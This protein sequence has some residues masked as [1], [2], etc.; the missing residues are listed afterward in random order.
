[1]PQGRR[2][3]AN[4]GKHKK[5]FLKG[6]R[7][8][9]RA[10]SSSIANSDNESV[11]RI[12]SDSMARNSE[13][14]GDEGI[15]IA[16]GGLTS[17]AIAKINAQPDSNAKRDANRYALH[18][19]RD[20]DK[21]VAGRQVI[22]WE[23]Y[24]LLPPE[25]LQ[26]K[27][28]DWWPSYDLAFPRRP[29]W[30][31][32]MTTEQVD[33]H[34]QES[35]KQFLES[36]ESEYGSL[37]NLSHFELNLE[38][39]RQLWRV[40]EMADIVLLVADIRYPVFHFP[41]AL[42][43]YTKDELKKS[44]ILVLNKCDLVDASVVLA[45]IDYFNKE[46]PDIHVVPFAS[47][48][49]MRIGNAKG[50]RIGRLAMA[51]ESC[52]RLSQ[53]C[54]KIV[55]DKVNLTEWK[56]KIERELKEEESSDAD[57]EIKPLAQVEHQIVKKDLSRYQ[58]EKYK[59][60]ILTI[61]CIGHPN[62]GK[63]SVLNA[64]MGKKVVSVSRTP[65][66]TKYFQ[67]IFITSNVKLVDCPGLVFPSKIPKSL[68]V[69]MGC[70]PIAQLREPY[71]CIRFIAERVDLPKLLSLQHPDPDEKGK[72]DQEWSAHEVCEAWA[73]K[74]GF[75]TAKAARPDVYRAANH[76][77]RMALDGR[78][79]CLAFYPPQFI[80]MRDEWLKHKDIDEIKRLQCQ[81][82]TSDSMTD[83]YL[84]QFDSDDDDHVTGA[85]SRRGRSRTRRDQVLKTEMLKMTSDDE[86][87]SSPSSRGQSTNKFA[88]LGDE[89]F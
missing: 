68:Q 64:I 57:E 15:S 7:E 48:A 26:V 66:H 79:I 10:R 1:M 70:F 25:E 4:S 13:D 12:R 69:L 80:S 20:S 5:E 40:T 34:E 65:G 27:S 43:K 38:T 16:K 75:K 83:E 49:G 89:D 9:R 18:F 55:A 3:V 8:Q 29:P 28:G 60:G 37:T 23:K 71:T 30:N 35:F 72:S 73:A 58:A 81:K 67:T 53:V 56:E 11:P 74:R 42:F 19:I 82:V 36:I 44:F 33:K 31:P 85:H 14:G 24:Q 87:S 6:K 2:R 39:W 63:S 84:K 46:Y 22:S 78:T 47:Y 50:K 54:S 77:L 88:L 51:G 45:W 41:P 62:V 86:G 21:E 32:S 52:K 59:D 76:L 61:G 17:A